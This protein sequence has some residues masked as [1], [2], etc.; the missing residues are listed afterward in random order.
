MTTVILYNAHV[1]IQ[2]IF[3]LKN[4]YVWTFCIMYMTYRKIYIAS[5]FVL[6]NRKI[7]FF[8]ALCNMT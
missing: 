5:Q 7:N 2:K 6:T 3:N 4:I 1:I 8:S